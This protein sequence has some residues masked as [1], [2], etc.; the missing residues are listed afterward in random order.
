MNA[1]RNP[2]GATTGRRLSVLLACL[3]A[4]ALSL[5][6]VS[7]GSA[8]SA[9]AKTLSI[10]A[11]TTGNYCDVGQTAAQCGLYA[12]KVGA[13]W[14]EV[15]VYGGSLSA[16]GLAYDQSTGV[17]SGTISSSAVGQTVSGNVKYYNDGS[18]RQ[19]RYNF[20]FTVGEPQT[21]VWNPA[22]VIYSY[23]YTPPS[24]TV[25]SPATSTG[26]ITYRA[27]VY[28]DTSDCI[29]DSATGKITYWSRVGEC[30]IIA[31]AAASGTLSASEV[32]R[33]IIIA[34]ASK[35]TSVSPSSGVAAGGNTVTITGTSFY[36]VSSVTFDGVAATSFTVNAAT[37][38][39]AVVP[40]AVRTG[41][42]S[43]IVSNGA[44]SSG[45]ATYSYYKGAQTVTWNPTTALKYGQSPVT[46]TSATAPGGAITYANV[47][48]NYVG[49][50]YPKSDCSVDTLTGRIGYSRLGICVV[51]ANAAATP[52]YLAG[53]TTQSFIIGKGDQVISWAPRE[54]F[55]PG[56]SPAYLAAASA[57]GGAALSYSKVST[58]MTSCS[59]DSATRALS[60]SGTGDC[61]IRVST[62]EVDYY[63]AGSKDFTFK[64]REVQSITISSPSIVSAGSTTGLT[65]SG[66]L[67]SGAKS[68]A[69]TSGAASCSISGD[70]L[71]AIGVGSCELVATVA[72]DST[73]ASATSAPQTVMVTRAP[74]T[75]AMSGSTPASVVAGSSTPL[76]ATGYSGTGARTFSIASG[77]TYCAIAGGNLVALAAGTCLV[78]VSI[79]DDSVYASTSSAPVSVEV[80]RAPRTLTLSA[81]ASMSATQSATLS[82]TG[83][84][85]TSPVVYSIVTGG[86]SCQLTGNALTATAVGS[87]TLQASQVDDTVYAAAT[88][89][90]VTVN[91]SRVTQVITWSPTTAVT[92]PQTP[93]SPTPA[94][95]L[96]SLGVAYAMIAD[97]TTGCTVN[98]TTGQLFYVAPG[99]CTVRASALVTDVY[100]AG[101]T[102]VTFT[103]TK[104]PSGIAW[105]TGSS[106][107]LATASPLLLPAATINGGG[108]L[109]YV[110]SS[111]GTTGCAVTGIRTLEFTGS[112]A[113]EVTASVPGD[114]SYLPGTLSR[115][116]TIDRAVQPLAWSPS[117][118]SAT[119]ADDTFA[120][121]GASTAE[122]GGAITYTAAPGTAGCSVPDPARP[123]LRFTS[124][125]TC[126]VSTTA[127]L[128]PVYESAT[129]ALTFSVALATPTMSWTPSTVI[130][131]LD[132]PHVP[133]VMATTTSDDTVA[134]A[135]VGGTSDC[136][137]NSS[138]GVL[139]FTT[140]GTCQVTGSTSVTS[141]YAAG[142]VAATFVIGRAV[143]P[144]TLVATPP[145]IT[146]G[147]TSRLSTTGILS[148]GAVSY[149]ITAGAGCS[150]SV[151]YLTASGPATCAVRVEVAEDDTFAAASANAIVSVT[152]A[153]AP[154]PPPGPTPPPG[155]VDPGG[156][157]PR[158]LDP[159]LEA[160]DTPPGDVLVSVGGE[161]V[162]VRVVPHDDRRGLAISSDGWS[163]DVVSVGPDDEPVLLDPDGTLTVTPGG[164]IRI[165]G[166]GFESMAQVRTYLLSGP[167]TLGAL[168]TDLS[169]DFEGILPVPVTMAP[170]A[171]ALQVNGF[172]PDRDVRS[173]TVGVSVMKPVRQGEVRTKVMFAESS[174]RLTRTAKDQLTSMLTLLAPRE[175]VHTTI[176]GVYLTRKGVHGKALAKARS[177]NVRRYLSMLGL[178]GRV[179]V[180][181]KSTRAI[182]FSRGRRV[183]VRN[184]S[185][186]AH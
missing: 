95:A 2:R 9:E 165:S 21:L 45:S 118:T 144:I 80:T 181:I 74:Q 92:I 113:C 126:S 163:V 148:T 12:F 171:N 124:V 120:F 62:P 63:L 61:I 22:S 117:V 41:S 158:A 147:A 111:P 43:V 13:Y 114:D 135:V 89:P 26:T 129:I 66:A 167:T 20:S 54:P 107:I 53:S 59:I 3:V 16:I 142:S 128:T 138:T 103:I 139:T 23:P 77:P 177:A 164:G 159:I 151:D 44:G 99:T 101:S 86:A 88:S 47:T 162:S 109:A 96:G 116:F 140:L 68:F 172:T 132:S 57:L 6:L 50:T 24:A 37:Q 8:P 72:E 69:V 25:T 180:Y 136:A 83:S 64:S 5:T 65:V 90:V 38:I 170:G 130:E 28:S 105:T 73:Y 157:L 155:P 34:G 98:P 186:E 169:G 39:T 85:G 87:C 14:D 127:A 10:D 32:Y 123:V 1:M 182:D 125:G 70:V 49:V 93:V 56:Y 104:A 156:P 173:V 185:I 146:V 75:I 160:A 52:I 84:S 178:Q 19:V 97:T 168:M 176:T 119:M 174:A 11:G 179:S 183:V 15:N 134:Y 7:W 175:H 112:G 91:V 46:P 17:W 58:T 60:Y 154:P 36:G 31:K 122:G 35:A 51:E 67:G 121:G 110:V 141:R 29:V 27:V 79:A 106:T 100:E 18:P 150:L 133:T 152:A 108:N 137:V 33:T 153:P 94:S 55:R 4:A 184:Y 76:T 42:F 149:S 30:N 102:D 71:T 143:R 78:G 115:V 40:Q 82:V 161:E 145:S 131:L 81:P 48:A 166:R